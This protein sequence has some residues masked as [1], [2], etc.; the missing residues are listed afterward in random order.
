MQPRDSEGMKLLLMS[1]HSLTGGT[2][3]YTFQLMEYFRSRGF[4]ITLLHL[5]N[6]DAEMT[7]YCEKH[8][9]NLVFLRKLVSRL[10]EPPRSILQDFLILRNYIRKSNADLIVATVGTPGR[11]LGAVAWIRRTLYIVH[12]IPTFPRQRIKL[13]LYRI[14]FAGLT[15]AGPRIITVS[16]FARRQIEHTWPGCKRRSQVGYCYSTAGPP[17][18]ASSGS[19]G[20]LLVLT[21]GHVVHYKGILQWLEVVESM[22]HLTTELELQFAWIGEGAMLGEARRI[23]EKAG[24]SGMVQL[25]GHQSNP[26][27]WY[28]RASIYFQPSAVENL[29]LS[30]L[31]ALRNG[32]P[33][34]ATE[35]G[36][37]PEQIIHGLN[38][39]ITK[40]EKPD[41]MRKAL[42]ELLNDPNLRQKMGEKSRYRYET[43]FTPE[44]WRQCMEAELN[45]LLSGARTQRG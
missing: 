1:D 44:R 31:D 5:L 19:R 6:E 28:S 18:A 25:P 41:E 4:A 2:R 12:T 3:T 26:E 30:V 45:G 13:W 10:H 29:S 11:F 32:L 37:L 27:D 23:I 9:I 39:F 14:L 16:E 7:E 20:P 22:R 43:L 24:L 38:G 36:G 42:M 15:A 17:I 8:G 40:A 34:V 21:V 33:C 35:V